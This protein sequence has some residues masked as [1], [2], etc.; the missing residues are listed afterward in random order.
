MDTTFEKFWK[1]PDAVLDYAVDWSGWVEVGET[2][3]SYTVT[4]TSGLT[5]VSDSEAGGVVTAWLSG[6]TVGSAYTVTVH[7]ITSAGR[8]DDRSFRVVI[9]QR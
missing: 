4:V 7:I 9:V 1:D 5:L 2:I 6:G 3:N 8:E